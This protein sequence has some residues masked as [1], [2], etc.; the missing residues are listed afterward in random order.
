[1]HG[2]MNPIEIDQEKDALCMTV[3]KKVLSERQ[4]SSR[5][6][7]TWG[8]QPVNN[9][10][11]Q[12]VMNVV[13]HMKDIHRILLVLYMV[14]SNA[15][16]G[17][18]QLEAAYQCYKFVKQNQAALNDV[19]RS[20][21][22]ALK[23]KSKYS[24]L[25]VQH[26]LHLYGLYDDDLSDLI[27]NPVELIKALYNR[28]NISNNDSKCDINKVAEEFAK[29]FGLKFYDVQMSLIKQWL[30]VGPT[31]EGGSLEQTLYDDELNSTITPTKD[32]DE[33]ANLSVEKYA[34]KL[35]FFF[36]IFLIQFFSIVIIYRAYYILK[37]WD[38]VKSSQFI[39]DN[40]FTGQGDG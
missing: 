7:S 1:M 37:S 26:Q 21:E 28:A 32:D 2:M 20:K 19:Q 12:S 11:L 29:L 13:N 25:K 22:L 30:A 18:D 10:F 31:D 36:S 38:P 39:I 6:N 40:I 34:F 23:I 8:L 3:F 24:V 9:A 16:E 15:P 17:A 14:L 35:E 5:E 33:N 27:A 4:T